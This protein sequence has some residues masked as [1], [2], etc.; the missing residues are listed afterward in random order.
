MKEKKRAERRQRELCA[1]AS[2]ALSP[3][4][5]RSEIGSHD[6]PPSPASIGSLDTTAAKAQGPPFAPLP[7]I[8]RRGTL[9]KQPR[10][11]CK[12]HALVAEIPLDYLHSRCCSRRMALL[13]YL[14]CVPLMV[15]VASALQCTDP[16]RQLWRRCCSI[17]LCNAFTGYA[18]P[19]VTSR[20]LLIHTRR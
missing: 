4:T 13:H 11:P 1:P 14:R 2:A 12:L 16:S 18:S 6:H 19:V 9:S 17:H 7:H 5:A 15:V 10:V 20:A 8:L 3:A